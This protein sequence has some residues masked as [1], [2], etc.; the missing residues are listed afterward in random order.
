MNFLTINSLRACR[1]ITSARQTRNDDHDKQDIKIQR[2]HENRIEI[3]KYENIVALKR[4]Q[5]VSHYS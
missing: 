4:E 5:N 1:T 2:K 3:E